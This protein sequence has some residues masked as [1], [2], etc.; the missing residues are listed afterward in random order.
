MYLLPRQQ[1]PL[2]SSDEAYCGLLVES[3]VLSPPRREWGRH[4]LIIINWGGLTP[5]SASALYWQPRRICVGMLPG[6]VRR[7]AR[8]GVLLA[9]L[10]NSFSIA[11][12]SLLF[13]IV[14]TV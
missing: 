14:F 1:R 12:L 2:T 4:G 10:S 9:L 8:D 11:G 5:L 6:R 13:C 3:P 7:V